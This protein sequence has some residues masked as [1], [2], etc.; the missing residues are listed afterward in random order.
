MQPT[1]SSTQITFGRSIQTQSRTWAVT[2]D[3]VSHGVENAWHCGE[4]VPRLEALPTAIPN[5][6]SPTIFK[7]DVSPIERISGKLTLSSPAGARHKS[8][9]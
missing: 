6:V 5:E 1:T 7:V 3:L 8:S 9:D 2:T 4:P